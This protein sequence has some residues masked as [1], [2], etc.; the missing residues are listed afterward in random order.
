MVI[1]DSKVLE[2]E[3]RIKTLEAKHA[4]ETQRKE[5]IITKLHKEKKELKYTL[6]EYEEKVD[7]LEDLVDSL[8]E[9][10][11]KFQKINE[12]IVTK[13]DVIFKELEE[14]EK[15]N[16]SAKERIDT[17][18]KE[19]GKIQLINELIVQK[20]ANLSNESYNLK[21]KI[22][23]LSEEREKLETLCNKLKKENETML[24]GRKK[25][26]VLINNL[27]KESKIMLE[28]RKKSEVLIINL[29]RENEV[30]LVENGQ[31]KEMNEKIRD[32]KYLLKKQ[33]DDLNNKFIDIS[34]QLERCSAEKQ[35][36]LKSLRKFE[37]KHYELQLTTATMLKK[38]NKKKLK[39]FCF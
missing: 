5:K 29:K 3:S 18:M 11:K 7:D 21:K 6:L 19:N 4:K 24:E 39:M 10:N 26:E 31:F 13:N 30:N 15:T 33:Q 17:F 12:V 1:V 23:V 20:N 36:L 34:E 8:R 2:L 22:V 35:H 14:A 9:E 38:E 32:E 25:S 16:D 28:D 37:L 27:K